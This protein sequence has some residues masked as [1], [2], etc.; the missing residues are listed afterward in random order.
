M[1]N[2]VLGDDTV[3]LLGQMALKGFDSSQAS[4]LMLQY[5]HHESRAPLVGGNLSIDCNKAMIPSPYKCL[6][7]LNLITTMCK[8]FIQYAW[9]SWLVRFFY[10]SYK[11]ALTFPLFIAHKS[12]S[13]AWDRLVAHRDFFKMHERQ[14]IFDTCLISLCRRA[15]F[16]GKK[17]IILEGSRTQRG[18]SPQPVVKISPVEFKMV[19]F[20]TH[21]LWD[22]ACKRRLYLKRHRWE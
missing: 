19:G 3:G 10:C 16:L 6:G 1:H 8:A 21:I 11:V 15:A 12:C 22:S 5:K 18:H 13:A 17:G 2:R 14:F 20:N 7:Q 4:W 9:A